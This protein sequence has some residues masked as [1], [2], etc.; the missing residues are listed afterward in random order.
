M[1]YIVCIKQVPAVSDVKIDPETGT[2]VREGIPSIINPS[3]KEAIELALRL[4]HARPGEIIAISMGPP[5]AEDALREA[6]AMGIDHAYLVSDRAFAG[7][8]TLATSYTLAMTVRYLLGG[9]LVEPYLILCGAQAIDGD[10][11]QV[12]PELAEELGIPQVTCAVNA[13]LEDGVVTVEQAFTHH[14]TVVLAAPLPALITVHGGNLTPRLPSI[15]AIARAYDAATVH[16][17]DAGA[18]GA[19]PGRIGLAGS[20]TQVWKVFS[21]DRTIIRTRL[22][23]TPAEIAAKVRALLEPTLDNRG[24]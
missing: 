19:D 4:K 17:L 2:L 18:I 7:A 9:S 16:V 1:K 14:E 10:T 11:A 22:E 6:L 3:D 12:G 15:V 5:Q 24:A 20:K 23:G 13:S 8:D 21:P